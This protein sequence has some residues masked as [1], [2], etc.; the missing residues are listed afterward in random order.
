MADNHYVDNKK[1]YECI[2]EYKTQAILAKKNKQE[3]PPIPNYVGECILMIGENLSHKPNFINYSFRDEMISDGVEN[4]VSYFDN[5]DPAKSTNP[6]AYFTQIIYYAFL[7]RILKEKK[8]TYIKHKTA[9]NSMLFDSIVE[10]NEFDDK[11]FNFTQIDVDNQQAVE[12]IK[13]FEDNLKEKKRK[14]K[15]KGLEQFLEE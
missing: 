1:L 10:Q 15:K 9:E 7:R 12:F 2:V 11:E 6:F 8:Q 5:F 4:C 14:K 13:S 3:K